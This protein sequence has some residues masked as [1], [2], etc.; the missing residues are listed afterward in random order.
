MITLKQ[1]Q[2]A[3]KD[4][5]QPVM[6]AQTQQALYNERLADPAIEKKRQEYMARID[7]IAQ[8]DKKLAGVYSDPSS[9][10]YLE[11]PMARE[12]IIQG[13]R[14][15]TQGYAQQGLQEVKQE[16]QAGIEDVQNTLQL[17]QQG[18]AEKERLDKESKKS[19]STAF[20]E[21]DMESLLDE[22][23]NDDDSIDSLL[24]ELG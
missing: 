13:A 16:Q 2:D 17:L 10:L 9:Q 4:L 18:Q 24:E 20:G 5:P 23:N 14:P 1:L 7:Q 21:I 22:L 8:M 6:G 15:V 11:N 12:N 19:V 3:L